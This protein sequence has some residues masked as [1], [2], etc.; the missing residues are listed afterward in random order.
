MAELLR[1]AVYGT[2][3]Y[4]PEKKMTNADFEK[5]LDTSDEWI[6]SR[7]GIKTRRIAAPEQA[8]SD[9]CLEAAKQALDN[10]GV[11]ATD[12]DLI[13]TATATP[14]C[15]SMPAAACNVQHRLGISA[16]GCGAVDLTAACTG[17]VYA[18][19]TAKAHVENGTCRRVL[20]LG[21]ET[22]SRV[23]DYQDR[24]TCILFGDGA[25]AAV[26][27]P[28]RTDG[29]SHPIGEVSLHADGSG[30]ELLKLPAGGSR[31]PASAETVAKR[32]HFLK[33]EGREIFRFGVTKMIEMISGIM[34][35][36]GWAA[37]DLGLIV[38][39]QANSRIIDAAV[40]RLKLPPELFFQNLAEYGNT[41]A[42]TIPIAL[43]E[44][45]RQGRIPAGKPVL[46]IAFG[47]GL[48]WGHIVI[49][50]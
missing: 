16:G 21:G 22:L 49:E 32:Q 2:G 44:A 41:S 46:L 35:R 6:V 38:P 37:E 27:G 43:D 47:G 18:L 28:Q 1:A 48:T 8:T 23:T 4:L 17:F 9:L 34:E 39:H 10:A 20:A 40:H 5:F 19:A 42:A 3:S 50:W 33:M 30:G 15:F 31:H 13:I 24:G 14:D 7:T 12:L 25:G 29:S 26:V 11:A 45:A 36:H